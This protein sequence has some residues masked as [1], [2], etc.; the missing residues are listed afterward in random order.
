[1]VLE[2]EEVSF[3]FLPV[4][5]SE[6]LIGIFRTLW[7]WFC[8]ADSDSKS[9]NKSV[10]LLLLLRRFKTFEILSL[11]FSISPFCDRTKFVAFS[12]EFCAWI[13]E[14][15]FNDDDSALNLWE[16]T[17]TPLN[18]LEFCFWKFR[19]YETVLQFSE[20]LWFFDLTE[21]RESVGTCL[22]CGVILWTFSDLHSGVAF[23]RLPCVPLNQWGPDTW[24]WTG[25][26]GAQD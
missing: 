20:F 11:F 26:R 4:F 18:S 2:Y 25:L 12:D 13:A 8:F 9:E 17:K 16:P 14:R 22:W 15:R 23:Y 21:W 19:V 24:T 3:W 5:Y 6:I 7:T 10:F 1:V